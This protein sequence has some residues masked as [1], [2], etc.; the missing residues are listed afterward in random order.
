VFSM[1]T[2]GVYLSGGGSGKGVMIDSSTPLCNTTS[3]TGSPRVGTDASSG[4][5]GPTM[6]FFWSGTNIQFVRTDTNSVVKTFII[7]HP[8]DPDRHLVHATTESPHNG[9]EYWGVA[10]IV[11][12]RAEVELPGYFEALCSLDN[13]QV[14]VSVVLP[15]EDL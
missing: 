2:N 5:T 14:Q 13:R 8:V 12:G 10:E 15:D 4:G 6:R 1:G 9:V 3:G 7:D 11:G